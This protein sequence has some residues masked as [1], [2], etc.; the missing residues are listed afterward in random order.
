MEHT[1]TATE[2]FFRTFELN[3]SSGDNQTI[4]AQFADVFMAAGPQG[5]QAVKATD[6]ALALPRR[7]Q[8]FNA[9][10]LQAT[11]LAS[12]QETRL[13]ARFVLANIQW[14]MTFARDKREPQDV[15]VDSV[16]I[17][18]L[19]IEK[20]VFYLANQDIVKVLKE[21]GIIPD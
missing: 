14:R 19:E 10:G 17:V 11:A 8:M 6:F 21:S 13:D 3:N 5:T 20:I 15:L 1:A 18:D 2:R 9:W 16:F 7:K 4:V 12:L